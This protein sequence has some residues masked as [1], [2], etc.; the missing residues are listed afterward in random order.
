ME[1]IV[2]SHVCYKTNRTIP[3]NYRLFSDCS[4]LA[5]NCV[6]YDKSNDKNNNQQSD[7]NNISSYQMIGECNCECHE[8][9][10]NSSYGTI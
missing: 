1:H 9:N 2:L 7:Q 10:L 3:N 8:N 5:N 6:Y 4:C